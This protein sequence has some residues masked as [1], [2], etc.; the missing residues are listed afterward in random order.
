[1]PLLNRLPLLVA[2]VLLSGMAWSDC[3]PF[4]EAKKHVGEIKCVT[5]TV[6][7][8]KQGARGVHFLDFAMTSACA[9]SPS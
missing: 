9:H 2:T 6:V 1:M 4:M 8:V 3:L 5:G 7:R